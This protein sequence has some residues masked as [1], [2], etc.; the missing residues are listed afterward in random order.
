[1]A[2]IIRITNFAGFVT[3]IE[4]D[5]TFVEINGVKVS[6]P[7]LKVMN[8]K[9]IVR[10]FS[11]EPDRISPIPFI[12]AV[13]TATGCGLTEGRL[14]MEQLRGQRYNESERFQPT[15]C[16]VFKCQ[17]AFSATEFAAFLAK[18]GLTAEFV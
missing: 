17:S 18:H 7:T 8:E 12:K 5:A 9:S 15:P 13:R 6:I 4:T 2:N 10:V 1:M 11:F 3:T 16:I 14:A